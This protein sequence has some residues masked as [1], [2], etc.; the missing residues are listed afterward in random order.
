M[1][2]DS[3]NEESEN[4]Y[5]QILNIGNLAHIENFYAPIEGKEQHKMVMLARE[6]DMN[7]EVKNDGPTLVSH[8]YWSQYKAK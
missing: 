1:L 4:I 3:L 6:G 5:S 7:H 8:G 2:L